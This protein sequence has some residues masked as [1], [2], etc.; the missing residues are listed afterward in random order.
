MGGIFGTVSFES[1]ARVGFL[2]AIVASPFTGETTG[3][4]G[5][6]SAGVVGGTDEV[7]ESMTSSF[8]PSLDIYDSEPSGN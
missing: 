2:A 6:G 1:E 5:T 8:S 3:A 4:D 7:R